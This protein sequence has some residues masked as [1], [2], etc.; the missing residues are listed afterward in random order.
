MGVLTSF[1]E[2]FE[3]TRTITLFLLDYSKECHI[4]ASSL[5][6]DLFIGHF[7]KVFYKKANS[8]RNNLLG[9]PKKYYQLIAT[10]LH[11]TYNCS[12]L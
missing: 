3:I 9:P 2:T 7:P 4:D 10:L 11:R 6:K 1:L 5:Q 8:V 12:V